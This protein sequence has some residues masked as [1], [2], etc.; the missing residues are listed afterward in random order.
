MSNR[1][2][3]I[4][5]DNLAISF[6]I[7]DFMWDLLL[8][9]YQTLIAFSAQNLSLQ[10]WAIWV[11]ILYIYKIIYEQ[12]FLISSNLTFRKRNNTKIIFLIIFYIFSLLLLFFLYQ[13]VILQKK[14]RYMSISKLFDFEAC[15]RRYHW[16]CIVIWRSPESHPQ[17]FKWEFQFR[18]TDSYSLFWELFKT[19]Q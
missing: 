15:I 16:S 8:F 7:T 1:F 9:C 4:S 5:E 19:L 12:Y 6:D 14:E 2:C 10:V 13:T 17:L 3:Q 11:Y 18:I